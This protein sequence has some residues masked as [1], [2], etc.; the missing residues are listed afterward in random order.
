MGVDLSIHHMCVDLSIDHMGVD[1]SIDRGLT[2]TPSALAGETCC[3]R[4][5]A[6]AL[7]GETCPLRVKATSKVRSHLLHETCGARALHPKIG[8][9]SS[10]G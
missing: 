2:E 6:T 3:L 7:A 1:L 9:G 8:L 4:V 5:K 10:R